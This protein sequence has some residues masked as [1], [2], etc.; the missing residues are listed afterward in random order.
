MQAFSE[1]GAKVMGFDLPTHVI[2]VE[3][4][5]TE[6]EL[7]TSSGARSYG[8]CPPADNAWL[9]RSARRLPGPERV[10]A[11]ERQRAERRGAEASSTGA[12][13]HDGHGHLSTCSK[14]T[15]VKA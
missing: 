2:T 6:V 4:K 12:R 1:V 5:A 13:V 8:R 9:S 15:L 11:A 3:A 14:V 10:H 7:V